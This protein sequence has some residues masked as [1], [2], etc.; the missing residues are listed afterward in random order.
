[1]NELDA[2]CASLR[3][4]KF[5]SLQKIIDIHYN[6]LQAAKELYGWKSVTEYINDKTHSSMQVSFIKNMFYRTEKKLGLIKSDKSRKTVHKENF[7]QDVKKPSTTTIEKSDNSNIDFSN[8]TNL[9]PLSMKLISDHNLTLDD[10]NE[11]GIKGISDK[12]TVYNKI[13]RFCEN[14]VSQAK[15]EKYQDIMKKD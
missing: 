15:R 6:E 8:F 2:F 9:N 11:I 7:N 5:K 10:L 13:N 4:K 1:M 12:M 14:K 3:E